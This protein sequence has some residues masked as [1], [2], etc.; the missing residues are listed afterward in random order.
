MP[1]SPVFVSVDVE[2]S[3]PSPSRHALLAIGA[4]LV[5]DPDEGFYAELKPGAAEAVPEAVAV[6]GLDLARLEREGADPAEA[7]ADFEAWLGRVIPDGARPVFVGFNASFDWMWVCD[8]FHR[9]L[10]RNPFGHSALDVKAL[11][12]GRTGMPWPATG[13]TAVA[14]RFGY[15]DA[16]PHHALDDARLQAALFRAILQLPP[17]NP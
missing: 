17:P 5:D 14:A 15:T 13:F 9:H 10:G 4:C 16:L 7:F 3:G 6:S 1:A 11:Y 2:T 8:G 12:M